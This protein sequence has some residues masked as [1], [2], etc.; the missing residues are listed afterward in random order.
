MESAIMIPL[1][2]VIAIVV[3]AIFLHFVPM[4]I[5]TPLAREEIHRPIGTKCRKIA[6]TRITSTIITGTRMADSMILPP[7]F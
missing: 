7:L 4:E 1:I 6:S 2:I 3:L 5:C